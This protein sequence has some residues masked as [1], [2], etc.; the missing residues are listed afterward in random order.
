MPSRYIQI[1]KCYESNLASSSANNLWF[2]NSNIIRKFLTPRED[3]FDGGLPRTLLGTSEQHLTRFFTYM[4]M[5]AP[6]ELGQALGTPFY[7]LETET[8]RGCLTSPT[9]HS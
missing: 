3:C 7:T 5:F 9:S 8:Q 6:K 2:N 4:I 1:F